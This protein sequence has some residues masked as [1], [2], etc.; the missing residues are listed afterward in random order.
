MM[1]FLRALHQPKATT[2]LVMKRFCVVANYIQAA[3]LG[4]ALRAKRA[5]NDVAAGLNR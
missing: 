5:N 1:Q 4:R 3:A 2:K